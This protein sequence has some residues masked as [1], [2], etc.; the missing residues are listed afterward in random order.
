MRDREWSIPRI[1]DYL[2]RAELENIEKGTEFTR[3]T[4]FAVVYQ[5]NPPRTKKLNYI[6]PKGRIVA[7]VGQPKLSEN[8]K[9]RVIP[10]KGRAGALSEVSLSKV[11]IIDKKEFVE[12][13]QTNALSAYRK[14]VQQL[15]EKVQKIET[16]I[17]KS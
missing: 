10:V 4:H 12:S 9:D 13:E 2:D 7:V 16:I 14:R 15:K 1:F 3:N 11:L 8:R 5:P 17:G 6:P